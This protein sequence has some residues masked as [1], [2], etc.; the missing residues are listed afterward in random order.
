MPKSRESKMQS[1]PIYAIEYNQ[2]YM[3]GGLPRSARLRCKN[4]SWTVLHTDMGV[5]DT[6]ALQSA[7]TAIH[8]QVTIPTFQDNLPS[9]LRTVENM[10]K[11]GAMHP[12][13][14]HPMVK[15]SHDDGKSW[16]VIPQ[17]E[18]DPELARLRQ[19]RENI[20]RKVV[21]GLDERGAA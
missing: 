2:P 11:P 21:Y 18:I 7:A 8:T 14:Y 16:S 10:T 17:K 20:N 1:K 15:I 9:V 4:N 13:L 3:S 5:T 12:E 19:D 6:A